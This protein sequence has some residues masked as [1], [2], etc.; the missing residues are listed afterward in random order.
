MPDTPVP[1]DPALEL[2]ASHEPFAEDG[3]LRCACGWRR[4]GFEDWH[5][6]VPSL[7]AALRDDGYDR[8]WCEG[9]SAVLREL[10]SR[11]L[12]FLSGPEKDG[13]KE[14]WIA[15]GDIFKVVGDLQTSPQPPRAPK[16]IPVSAALDEPTASEAGT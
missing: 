12:G 6:H 15:V 13:V 3:N 4:V 14:E 9:V 10:M 16:C 5:E 11:D 2:L 8:G 1:P 7:L